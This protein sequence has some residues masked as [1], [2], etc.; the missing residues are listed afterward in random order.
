MWSG[1][2]KSTSSVKEQ[3]MAGLT[4]VPLQGGG[5]VLVE[6]MAGLDG[7]VKAGRVSDAIHE[8]PLGLQTALEPVTAMARAVLDQLREARP[9]EV[10]VEFGVNLAVQAGAVITKSEANCHLK[11]KVVWKS[12]ESGQSGPNTD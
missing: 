12:G 9:D 5:S 6:D 8:L 4:R 3:Q 2:R 10:E 1:H 7:P 11:V